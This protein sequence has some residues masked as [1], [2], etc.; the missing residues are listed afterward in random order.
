MAWTYILR[1]GD[2][3]YYVG[4][5]RNLEHRMTQHYTGLGSAY[6]RG[7]M[8]V[9]LVWAQEFAD[10]GDAYAFEKKIQGW[11]RA[12]REALIA[13]EFDRLPALSKKRSWE[14]EQRD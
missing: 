7:R 10:I 5:A 13:G 12:K 11:S 8:P 1:C 4:S 14:R 6:T 3:S 9:T 2:G